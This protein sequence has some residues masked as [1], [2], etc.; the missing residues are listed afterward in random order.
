MT[1]LRLFQST[2]YPCSYLPE[3]NAQNLCTAPN[4]PLSPAIYDELITIG[5]RRS[6]EIVLRPAC[7][8]C[9][10]CVSL[11]IPVADF[12][13][14]KSQRRKIKA[15][16][17]INVNLVTTPD[18]SKY[19]DLYAQYITSKH[20]ESEEMQNVDNIFDTF[21]SSQWSNT[22]SIEFSLANDELV[23]V[24]ICD[25]LKDGWSDVYTFYNPTMT[26]RSLGNFAILA[27]IELLKQRAEKYLYLGYW[28]KDC[29]KMNY[30]TQYKPCEGFVNDQWILLHD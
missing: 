11:R 8:H 27:Q 2:T 23:C 30:K 26:K 19:H 4:S 14:S 17:D 18:Y 16:N 6:G 21:L 7:G 9:Q 13:P 1:T 24:A 28:I 15:N 3:H 10:Q 29:D 22:F 20:A 25:Q 12:L 5:F